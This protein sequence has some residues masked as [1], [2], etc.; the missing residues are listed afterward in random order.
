M[1][2]MFNRTLLLILLVVDF[3]W[4]KSSYGKFSG[5]KFVAGMEGTL[6]KFAEGNPY[7]PIKEFLQS[8]AMPNASLFGVLTMWGEALVGLTL[9]ISIIWLLFKKDSN[10]TASLLLLLGLLGGAF[11][12]AVFY[13]SS[14]WTSPSSESLNL[15]MF[16]V[17]AIAA[18]Y[19]LKLLLH[20]NH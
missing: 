5:G 15:L 3:I 13:F 1:K 16:M 11:L 17:E 4:L 14:G 20:I 18:F 10:N 6:K 9:L 19:T 7:P 2:N 8:V 12:N